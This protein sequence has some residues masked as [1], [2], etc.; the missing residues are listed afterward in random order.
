MFPSDVA[1]L[2]GAVRRR[3][4]FEPCPADRRDRH[5]LPRS[6]LELHT[7]RSLNAVSQDAEDLI[8]SASFASSA[9]KHAS[10]APRSIY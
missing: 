3:F 9:V 5:G 4:V 8:Y 7:P 2:I 6:V 1:A 10:F